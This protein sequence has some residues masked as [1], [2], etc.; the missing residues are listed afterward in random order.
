M[1]R[2]FRARIEG[3][4]L[5]IIQL[6]DDVNDGS[7][8]PSRAHQRLP[9]SKFPLGLGPDSIEA[10]EEVWAAAGSEWPLIPERYLRW[11]AGHSKDGEEAAPTRF[12]SKE[13]AFV[14]GNHARGTI[15]K[16]AGYGERS[17]RG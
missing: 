16:R 15:R 14:H 12:R 8:K 4:K 11:E 1:G 3:T 9:G 10:R 7:S 6:D 17:S 13:D 2:A 5:F